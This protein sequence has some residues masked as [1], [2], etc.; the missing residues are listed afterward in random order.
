MRIFG[1]L[2]MG[3]EIKFENFCE[4]D[5]EMDLTLG[6]RPCVGRTVSDC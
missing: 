3:L 2:L 1:K 6:S 5:L 4:K